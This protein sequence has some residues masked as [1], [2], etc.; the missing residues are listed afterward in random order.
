MSLYVRAGDVFFTHSETALGNM[1][2]WAET[3]P[4]ETNG[5]WA[6]HTGVVVEDGWLI[7]PAPLVLSQDYPTKEPIEARF[8][9]ATVIEALWKTRRGPLDTSTVQVRVFRPVPSL[10]PEELT[11]FIARAESFVG[12]TYGWWKLLV[13]LADRAIF[14]GRKIL[15]TAMY[16]DKRPICSYLAAKVYAFAESQSR[17]MAR[18]AKTND[19]ARVFAF[20]MPPQ[21]AD[22]DEMLDYCIAH[23]DEWEEVL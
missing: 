13:Q 20:G 7:P 11:R 1:I 14:K 18:F 5:T 9:A 12:A 21:A 2:R 23:P 22:P 6:N 3:D 16:L 15:T 19:V 10:T 4:G 17:A 8:I